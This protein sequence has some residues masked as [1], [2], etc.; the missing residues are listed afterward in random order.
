VHSPSKPHELPIEAPAE[1]AN[2]LPETAPPSSLRQ[3][4]AAELT[5][6]EFFLLLEN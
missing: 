2:P 4:P 3:L 5:T 1:A 6:T